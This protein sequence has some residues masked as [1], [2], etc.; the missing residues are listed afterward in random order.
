MS[1]LWFWT[2]FMSKVYLLVGQKAILILI[3]FQWLIDPKPITKPDVNF[4]YKTSSFC[5]V[6]T[7]KH[8]HTRAYSCKMHTTVSDFI[9]S[10]QSLTTHPTKVDSVL[11]TMKYMW[12]LQGLKTTYLA[13]HLKQILNGIYFVCEKWKEHITQL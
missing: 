3:A 10:Y 7:C 13:K 9:Y 5:H 8:M 6:N 12:G 4:Y 1:L 2:M 11:V